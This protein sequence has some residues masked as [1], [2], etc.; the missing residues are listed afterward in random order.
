MKL[1]LTC[2]ITGSQLENISTALKRKILISISKY[3][4]GINI[5]HIFE[6]LMYNVLHYRGNRLNAY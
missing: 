2:I 6:I 3:L 1:N 5:Q 4:K